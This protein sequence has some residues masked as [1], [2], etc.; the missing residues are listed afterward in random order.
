MPF[1]LNRIIRYSCNSLKGS[2]PCYNRNLSADRNTVVL[3]TE[4]SSRQS[5]AYE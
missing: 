5:L 2:Y 3:K 4:E 1:L